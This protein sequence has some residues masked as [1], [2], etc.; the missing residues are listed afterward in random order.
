MP[1]RQPWRSIEES[2]FMKD[3]PWCMQPH[4][5]EAKAERILCGKATV[6]VIS[7]KSLVTEWD[8][9]NWRTLCAEHYEAHMK[10]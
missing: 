2:Q 8:P 9:E 3:H 10:P 6:G 4:W 5:D 7:T 1:H